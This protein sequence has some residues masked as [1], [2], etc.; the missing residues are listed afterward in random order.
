MLYGKPK[1]VINS[2]INSF[3]LSTFLSDTSTY[4]HD[5]IIAPHINATRDISV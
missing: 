2:T 3:D 5:D 1:K 4:I